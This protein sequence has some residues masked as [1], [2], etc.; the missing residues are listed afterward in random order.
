MF[1][2]LLIN[3]VNNY[4]SHYKYLIGLLIR[5]LPIS[6]LYAFSASTRTHYHSEMLPLCSELIGVGRGIAGFAAL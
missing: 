4:N 1:S 3:F 5:Q 6:S 2:Y